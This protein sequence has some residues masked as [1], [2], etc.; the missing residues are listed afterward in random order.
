[1]P[2]Q[3][4]SSQYAQVYFLDNHYLT[5]KRK[6]LCM[7]VWMSAIMAKDSVSKLS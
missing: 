6:L 3:P 1:M 4:V 2:I 5:N 7:N